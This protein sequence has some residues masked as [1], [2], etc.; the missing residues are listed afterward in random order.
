M[1]A[2]QRVLAGCR[3][4]AGDASAGAR[5]RVGV[6]PFEPESL[7]KKALIV[8]GHV[9]GVQKIPIRGSY[10]YWLGV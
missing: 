2:L 3:R 4:M 7:Q 10:G 1:F 6:L 8:G 5:V 9:N